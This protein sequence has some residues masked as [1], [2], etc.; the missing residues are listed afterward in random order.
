MEERSVSTVT[1]PLTLEGA[2]AQ[3]KY[4]PQENLFIQNVTCDDGVHGP[5]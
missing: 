2:E 1:I 5:D 4:T 3:L